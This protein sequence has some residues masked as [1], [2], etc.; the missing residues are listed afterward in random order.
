[1]A[2]FGNYAHYYNVL[3]ADKNYAGESAAV[4]DILH[5]DGRPMPRTLLDLGCG[6]CRHALAM[7]R[8]GV[9]VTG[10]DMSANMLTMGREALAEA[11]VS[12][13]PELFEGD[14]RQVRLN[15]TFDAVT[16]LFHVMSYQNTEEDALAL[17]RTAHAHLR[18][19]GLFL[20]DFWFGPC[21]LKVRPEEREKTMGNELVRVVRKAVP[22]M[23]ICNDLVTVHYDIILHYN[24]GR[25]DATL[26]EDHPMRYWF[27]PELRHL[28]GQAGF[29]VLREG[30]ELGSFAAPG[31][32]CWTAWMLVQKAV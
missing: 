6:T 8:R 28:A 13:L 7:A 11:D 16:S 18:A 2:I 27:L 14:A 10:V 12:P 17:F 9:A 1:M 15:R 19:G 32:D 5:G 29:A 24:D 4:L 26:A 3:Y 31:D 30:G 25:P 20:F 21:V 22:H 23:D